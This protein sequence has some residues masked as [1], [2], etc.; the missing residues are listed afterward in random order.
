MRTQH[1]GPDRLLVA[2]KVQ[3]EASTTAV[4]NEKVRGQRGQD[5]FSAARL[6]AAKLV[7]IEPDIYRAGEADVGADLT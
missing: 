1:L 3:F 7:F 4:R 6:H 5:R 2:L